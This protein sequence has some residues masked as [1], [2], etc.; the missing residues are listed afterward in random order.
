[1]N[2]AQQR[3][4][5]PIHSGFN[6]YFPKA[7]RECARLSL[8]ANDQHNPGEPLHWAKGKSTDHPDALMRHLLDAGPNWDA[9]DD[10]GVMHVIKVMWRA[11][12]MAQTV[13][14]RKHD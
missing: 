13:L 3:K 2:K 11:C 7:I 12:A 10:D 9:V 4:A 6:M 8:V 1:M 14:E 5:C